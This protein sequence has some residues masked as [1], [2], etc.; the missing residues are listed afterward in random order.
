LIRIDHQQV[1]GSERRD[2]RT[3]CEAQ[4]AAL[5]ADRTKAVVDAPIKVL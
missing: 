5:G 4:T 2:S 1:S 3:R